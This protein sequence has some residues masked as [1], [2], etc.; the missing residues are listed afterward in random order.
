MKVHTL[1]Y[2]V[3]D[4]H[5]NKSSA[6]CEEIGDTIHISGLVDRYGNSVTFESDAHHLSTWVG[7]YGFKFRKIEKIQDFDSLW[8]TKIQKQ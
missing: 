1:I 6:T 5:G 8:E 4:N 3:K 7:D 2:L